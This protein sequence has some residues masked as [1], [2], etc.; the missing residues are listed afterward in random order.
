MLSR[1]YDAAVGEP[2][3]LV[4]VRGEV[5]VV[6]DENDGGSGLVVQGFEEGEDAGP[7]G[8][9][10]VAGGLVGEE[11]AG[12]VGEGAGDG[13]AL[14]FAAGELGREV[15]GAVGQSD[16]VEELVRARGGVWRAAELERD[17][18]VLEGGEGG[19]ELEALEHEADFFAAESCALIF[20][21]RGEVGAV[22]DHRTE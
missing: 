6:G 20:R 14:L 13:D 17:A 10:E 4:C 21:E 18:H 19:D 8:A 22:E 16:V 9:I 15:V 5:R 12:L 3:D 11:D 1:R 2:D 7:G